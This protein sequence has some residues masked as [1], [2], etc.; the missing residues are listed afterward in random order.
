M[1]LDDDIDK[2]SHCHQNFDKDAHVDIHQNANKLD[3]IIAAT[4]DH[5]N[6]I[7]HLVA[8][9]DGTQTDKSHQ[10]T[11]SKTLCNNI[12]LCLKIVRAHPILYFFLESSDDMQE[13]L[14]YI[15]DIFRR[16]IS[17]AKTH[18]DFMLEALVREE[19]L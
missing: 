7:F 18:T 11:A 1:L 3:E 9:E 4:T 17:N 10:G 13:T 8:C 2:T 14:G 15:V 16:E 12:S 5:S 6:S 19:F